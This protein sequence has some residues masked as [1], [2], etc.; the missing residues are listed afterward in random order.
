MAARELKD[1]RRKITTWNLGRCVMFRLL[2]NR[3]KYFD[4]GEEEWVGDETDKLG[5]M[6]VYDKHN[7]MSGVA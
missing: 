6:R 3:S 4:D 5:T 2:R 7:A 1:I